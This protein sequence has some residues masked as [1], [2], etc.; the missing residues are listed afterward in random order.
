MVFDASALPRTSDKTSL[1]WRETTLT[2]VCIRADGRIETA[3]TLV[4]KTAMLQSLA[5]DDCL[6]AAR[7]VQYPTRQEV[8]VVDD[9]PSVREA[10]P[11]A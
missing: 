7:Q 5:S 3:Y 8:M 1:R 4:A 9:L 6:L 2:F 10:L 11:P